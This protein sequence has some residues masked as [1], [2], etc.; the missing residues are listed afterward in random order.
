MCPYCSLLLGHPSFS[1]PF[2]NTQLFL[3]L[4]EIFPDF[5]RHEAVAS[6][7]HWKFHAPLGV[8]QWRG[9]CSSFCWVTIH[10]APSHLT[11]R[12]VTLS[13]LHLC[14]SLTMLNTLIGAEQGP[15][16]AVWREAGRLDLSWSVSLDAL[17]GIQQASKGHT[18]TSLLL[19]T[20]KSILWAM[21]DSP[22]PVVSWSPSFHGYLLF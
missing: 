6:S 21:Q 3:F 17:T 16:A 5:S 10:T 9:N 15:P 11:V 14:F 22:G 18:S 4:I 19:K 2:I 13:F 1:F 12:L 20:N 8:M 7:E